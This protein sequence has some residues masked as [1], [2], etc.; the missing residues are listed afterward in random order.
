MKVEWS[1]RAMQRAR[2]I[3]DF[4]AVDNVEASRM[5]LF[6]VISKTDQL[7]NFPRSG[8]IVPEYNRSDL[9]ELFHGKYRIVYR[10]TEKQVSI[11]T[12]WHSRRNLP[13]KEVK[14]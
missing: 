2:E 4:I 5:W 11:L 9:R 6:E 14:N 3:A 7:E 10:V 12:V 8:R 13:K 1:P